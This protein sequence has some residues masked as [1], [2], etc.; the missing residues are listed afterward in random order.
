MIRILDLSLSPR[1]F[2]GLR[3]A[4][5]RRQAC[6]GSIMSMHQGH[7]LQIVPGEVA[8]ARGFVHALTHLCAGQQTHANAYV[9]RLIGTIRREC[10]DHMIVLNERCLYRHIQNFVSTT[11]ASGRI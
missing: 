8:R 2:P 4:Y 11:I 1:P 10:L 7:S 6:V 9:E 5:A 3:G